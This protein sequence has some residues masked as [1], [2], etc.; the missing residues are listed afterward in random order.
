MATKPYPSNLLVFDLD[1][2]TFSEDVKLALLRSWAHIGQILVR[3]HGQ[4]GGGNVLRIMVKFGTRPYLRADEPGSDENWN[5]RMEQHLRATIR[6]VGNNCIAFNRAQRRAGQPQVA[7]DAVEFEL[8][9]RT[10]TLAFKPDSNS[11]LPLACAE[12]ATQVRA[13][14]NAGALDGGAGAGGAGAAWPVR[15]RVP[16]AASWTAQVAAATQA[17]EAAEAE[18]AAAAEQPDFAEEPELVQAEAA[19]AQQAATSPLEVAPMTEEEWQASY[20]VLPPDFSVDYSQA[21][22]VYADGSVRAFALAWTPQAAAG[23]EDLAREGENDDDDAAADEDGEPTSGDPAGATAETAQAA[24]ET[25]GE[26]PADS[27]KE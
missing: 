21:E 13:L 7:L 1:E 23:E 5:E 27:E 22:A 25:A 24:G 3:S 16:S 4:D 6:K 10:F 11:S 14:L 19:D 15:V 9:S 8:A 20:G 18:A 26:A 17:R 2:Q 12:V